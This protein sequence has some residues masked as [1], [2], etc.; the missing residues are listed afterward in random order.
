LKK[1]QTLTLALGCKLGLALAYT[2]LDNFMC[3][4][5]LAMYVLEHKY[6]KQC[7]V[8]LIGDHIVT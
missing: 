6:G 3:D 1:S 2:H 5:T 8:E 7:N 4:N